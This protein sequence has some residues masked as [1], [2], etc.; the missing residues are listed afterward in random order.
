VKLNYAKQGLRLSPGGSLSASTK[1]TQMHMFP[2]R[3]G[4]RPPEVERFPS[5]ITSR[6]LVPAGWRRTAAPPRAGWRSRWRMDDAEQGGRQP[7]QAARRDARTR[8]R[9]PASAGQRA[10]MRRGDGGRRQDGDALASMRSL[11]SGRAAPLDELARGGSRR[12]RL[13]LPWLSSGEE[14]RRGAGT[15]RGRPQTCRRGEEGRRPHRTPPS[16]G[17]EG[18]VLR[19]RRG[20]ARGW[21]GPARRDGGGMA[22]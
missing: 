13:P 4:G 10:W 2:S 5:L 19:L 20:K 11:P 9:C 12:P 7:S 6:Q 21:R 22:P 1:R 8:R 18:L 3:K 15:H 16:P 17:E 14:G